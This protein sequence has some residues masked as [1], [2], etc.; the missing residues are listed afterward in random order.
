MY[1]RFVH[2]SAVEGMSAR[3]GFFQVAADLVGDPLTP[4]EV[5]GSVNDIRK[6][7]GANLAAPPRFSRSGNQRLLETKGLSWF[8]PDARQHIQRAFEL[9]VLLQDS[10]FVIDCIRTSRPGY[11]VYE[12]DH[13]IVAEPFSDTW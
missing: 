12:D 9:K 11:V 1:I 13:Q 3:L 2:T 8:K 6:W 5:S 4:S 7:F 10:G